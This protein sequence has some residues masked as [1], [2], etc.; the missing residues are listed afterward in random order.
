MGTV[1][2]GM[3]TVLLP[4]FPRENQAKEPSDRVRTFDEIPK[5][6]DRFYWSFSITSDILI[7]NRLVQFML[8][9]AFLLFLQLPEY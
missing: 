4:G 7:K 5:L 8:R 6:R 3:G 2:S 9:P 1:L